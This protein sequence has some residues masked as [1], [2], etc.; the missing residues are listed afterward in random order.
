M[1]LASSQYR[2]N[3]N[4]FPTNRSLVTNQNR[5]QANNFSKPI[6]RYETL[7][8]RQSSST[9]TL[10]ASTKASTPGGLAPSGQIFSSLFRKKSPQFEV[11]CWICGAGF[12]SIN[13]S[14]NFSSHLKNAHPHPAHSPIPIFKCLPCNLQTPSK[15]D[16]KNHLREKHESKQQQVGVARKG[17]W[18]R[19]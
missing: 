15:E 16:W 19:R 9:N 12:K 8:V 14:E 6:T 11:R 5:S 10:P 2:S 18:K 13:C 7:P 3:V 1:H 17:F 4:T